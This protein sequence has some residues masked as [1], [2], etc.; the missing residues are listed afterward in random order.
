M[1]GVSAAPT[2][3]TAGP[4]ISNY[5]VEKFLADWAQ[6]PEFYGV[7]DRNL[8]WIDYEQPRWTQSDMSSPGP[9]QVVLNKLRAE[10]RTKKSDRWPLSHWP[11]ARA[12]S[13][14]ETFAK[15]MPLSIAPIPY[16]SIAD[17]GEINF[18]WK[19]EGLHVDLGM[20][21][22]GLFSYYADR[23]GSSQMIG[24]SLA[25]S[26]GMPAELVQLFRD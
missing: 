21:G 14:A 10:E 12:F 2:Q 1:L 7:N 4:Q 23:V 3:P 26:D 24:E 13:D 17:D 5:M 18:L 22:N 15:A 20:Y 25:V 6:G 11:S 19:S 9:L 8:F 16:I